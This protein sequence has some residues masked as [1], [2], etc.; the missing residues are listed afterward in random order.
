VINVSVD[1]NVAHVN[2]VAN[3]CP[4]CNCDPCDCNWG[5]DEMF[6]EG[7]SLVSSS[8][9]PWISGLIGNP[10]TT[11]IED[12]RLPDFE[13]IFNSFGTGTTHPYAGS[14]K[15]AFMNFN[16]KIGDLVNW[17]PIY[18][19]KQADKIWIIKRV[20]THS[21]LDCA[22]YDVEITDGSIIEAVAFH[23]IRKLED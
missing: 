8:L 21:P 1:Q 7:G 10:Y 13:S 20:F 11:A 22:Y 3:V 14:Y 16:Y 19:T 12:L 2:V 17:F 23:E 18:N 15:G 4:Y 6:E 9:A 5:L